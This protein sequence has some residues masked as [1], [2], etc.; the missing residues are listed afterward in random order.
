MDI[1]LFRQKEKSYKTFFLIT[2]KNA[3]LHNICFELNCAINR[4]RKIS[5][6]VLNGNGTSGYHNYMQ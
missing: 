2:V 6:V 1:F 3:Y 4:L 5:I